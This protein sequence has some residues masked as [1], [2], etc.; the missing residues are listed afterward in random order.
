MRIIILDTLQENRS[1]PTAQNRPS[2]IKPTDG[3][4]VGF[5]SS[6]SQNDDDLGDVATNKTDRLQRSVICMTWH[7]YNRPFCVV[8]YVVRGKIIKNQFK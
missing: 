1:K 6:K 7:P 8:G 2:D 5:N 3:R 4:V